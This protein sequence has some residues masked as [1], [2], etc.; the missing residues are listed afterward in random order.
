MNR[1]KDGNGE[2][3]VAARRA[4]NEN[5]PLTDFFETRKDPSGPLAVPPN[6]MF[7]QIL[8]HPVP[9]GAIL[10]GFRRIGRTLPGEVGPELVPHVSEPCSGAKDVARRIAASRETDAFFFAV[11]APPNKEWILHHER[12]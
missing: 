10:P 7:A 2:L 12:L 6:N 3:S 4:T 8:K 1:E 11:D 5:A 9:A